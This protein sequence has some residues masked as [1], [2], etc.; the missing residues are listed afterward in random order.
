MKDCDEPNELR[1]KLVVAGVNEPS[2]TL[3]SGVFVRAFLTSM[4]VILALTL[5]H[6]TASAQVRH[7]VQ[8][9][10]GSTPFLI[11]VPTGFRDTATAAP[12]LREAASL[13]VTPGTRVLGYF[14]L[15]KELDVYSIGR[16]FY[17]SQWLFAQTPRKTEAI[18]ATQAQFDEL[19]TVL[20]ALQ[21]D[22]EKKIEP[23]LSAE[24]K[25]LAGDLGST[26]QIPLHLQIGQIV[27]ISINVN[28]SNLFSYTVIAEVET[29]ENGRVVKRPFINTSAVCY[30]QGKLVILNAYQMFQAPQDIKAS[31][32]FSE[33]WVSDFFSKNAS[34]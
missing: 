7:T 15:E 8:E 4:A 2:S 23:R 6:L 24:V 28:R 16:D 19:R 31:R 10:I 20:L 25:R 1:T 18:V 30:V 22:L 11:P 9:R 29:K 17:F 32:A 26:D 13:F 14:V 33:R 12:D 3:F 34:R 5:I 21:S 27:P